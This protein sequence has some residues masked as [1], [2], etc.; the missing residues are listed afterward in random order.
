M[1]D[2]IVIVGTTAVFK[3]NVQSSAPRATVTVTHLISR[4]LADLAAREVRTVDG[5]PEWQKIADRHRGNKR[6]HR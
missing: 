5:T 2:R 3:T 6:R 1:G 4:G